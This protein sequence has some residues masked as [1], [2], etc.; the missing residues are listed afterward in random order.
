MDK[1]ERYGFA[2]FSIKAVTAL[3]A[4]FGADNIAVRDIV[5]NNGVHLT[6]VSLSGTE[7]DTCL[8]ATV[9]LDFGYADYIEHGD[10]DAVVN[11]MI[12]MLKQKVTPKDLGLQ[13]MDDLKSYESMKEF[14]LPTL[15]NK[16]MNKE[17][18]R[19]VPNKDYLDMSI[20]YKIYLEINE[21]GANTIT[22][23]NRLMETWGISLDELH[24]M[25]ID[26]LKS[27]KSEI[28]KPVVTEM[29]ELIMNMLSK[30]NLS[31]DISNLVGALSEKDEQEMYV[32]TNTKM[33]SGNMLLLN[34]DFVKELNKRFTGKVYCIPSSVEEWI[35]LVSNHEIDIDE[36]DSLNEIIRSINKEELKAESVLSDHLYV[37]CEKGLE[38]A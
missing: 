16:K 32:V 11:S 27:K 1:T 29:K 18:L 21:N 17:M 34:E 8:A 22:I 14:I 13:S 19:T 2:V 25:A 36:R 23:N 26:N 20:V 30:D 31:A 4:E 9:Y 38:I 24:N 6:G 10:F 7:N 28:A 15:I 35:L 5:K 3:K 33:I 37:L 12:N